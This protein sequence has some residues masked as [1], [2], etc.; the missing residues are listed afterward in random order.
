MVIEGSVMI[1]DQ[2]L[3]KRDAMGVSET[4][5]VDIT[6]LENSDV[7]LFEVPMTIGF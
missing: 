2:K 1:K 4:E 6:A 3:N 7:I 5:N